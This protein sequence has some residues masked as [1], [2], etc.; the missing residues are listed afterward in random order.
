MSGVVFFQ[1]EAYVGRQPLARLS[2]EPC[3]VDEFDDSPGLL[4]AVY[5]AGR[6]V[7]STRAFC[8][9]EMER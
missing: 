8:V 1:R 7:E 9:V 6:L 4:G 3:T 5:R 2:G